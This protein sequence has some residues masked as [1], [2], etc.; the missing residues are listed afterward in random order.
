MRSK[1]I[2]K[3]VKLNV[4]GVRHEVLWSTLDHLPHTRLGRLRECNTYEGISE[5]CDDYNVAENEYFFDRH[6][7]SFGSVLNFYRTGKWNNL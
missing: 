4:G 7:K 1:A 2:N 3:R 6:P 5:L